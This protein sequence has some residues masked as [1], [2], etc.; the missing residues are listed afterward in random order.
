M[1][2]LLENGN[3]NRD[4]FD[5]DGY[6]PLHLATLWNWDKA[7]RCLIEDGKFD[8]EQRDSHGS[9]PLHIAAR[10]NKLRS[11]KIL[12]EL[13]ADPLSMNCDGL[14]PSQIAKKAKSKDIMD[15]LAT[16]TPEPSPQKKKKE[17]GK[18]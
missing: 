18:S 5:K 17:K 8:I 1:K 7:I 2:I 4:Q 13:N 16:N 10:W 9:H 12:L 14:T 6:S 15:L 11:S 3:F